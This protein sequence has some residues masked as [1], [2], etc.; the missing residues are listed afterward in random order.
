M[1]SIKKAPPPSGANRLAAGHICV[2]ALLHD[3]YTL[4]TKPKLVTRKV[5]NGIRGCAYRTRKGC[6][7]RLKNGSGNGQLLSADS[8]KA[9]KSRLFSLG[10]IVSI[11]TFSFDRECEG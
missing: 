1:E 4:N 5:G 7:N 3:T 8:K 9:L 11:L 6:K 2:G 10:S